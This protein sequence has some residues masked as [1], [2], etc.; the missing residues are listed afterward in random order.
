[1]RIF[2]QIA[3][4]L[5]SFV[6]MASSFADDWVLTESYHVVPLAVDSASVSAA[7]VAEPIVSVP[8]NQPLKPLLPRRQAQ[9]SVPETGVAGVASRQEEPAEQE[10]PFKNIMASKDLPKERIV[11]TSVSKP[12]PSPSS[13]SKLP[14]ALLPTAP[15]QRDKESPLP[16]PKMAAQPEPLLRGQSAVRH[17]VEEALSE[18][19]AY[20]EGPVDAGEIDPKLLDSEAVVPPSDIGDPSTAKDAPKTPAAQ[21]AKNQEQWVSG[22]LLLTTIIATMVACYAVILAFEFRQRWMQTVTEQNSRF[23]QGLD[24]VFDA[25]YGVSTLYSDAPILSRFGAD[26]LEAASPRF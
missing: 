17:P 2:I 5:T 14:P 1:M 24:D 13:V 11:Q 3:V 26:M 4:C 18:P 19:P 23:A 10:N 20:P 9:I 7:G 6:V 16:V 15:L 22:A 25:D 12:N 21:S 8:L